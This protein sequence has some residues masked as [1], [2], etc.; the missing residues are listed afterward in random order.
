HGEVPAKW[1]IRYDVIDGRAASV[2]HSLPQIRELVFAAG[3]QKAVVD[4]SQ[5]ANTLAI[6]V[7]DGQPHDVGPRGLH[8]PVHPATLITG[9]RNQAAPPARRLNPS[10]VVCAL[11]GSFQP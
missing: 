8:W 6:Q 1:R 10:A 7:G 4:S 11:D 5:D 2:I 3:Q 9:P